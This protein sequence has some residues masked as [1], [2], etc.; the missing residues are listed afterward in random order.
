MPLKVIFEITVLSRYPQLGL[1]LHERDFFG[2][3][4]AF[5]YQLYSKN[6]TLWVLK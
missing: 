5:I 2:L 4:D 1:E 3:T 6:I